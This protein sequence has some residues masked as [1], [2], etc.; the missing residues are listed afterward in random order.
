MRLAILM[1]KVACSA[2]DAPVAASAD[3]EI[4]VVFYAGQASFNVRSLHE[5]QVRTGSAGNQLLVTF[6][7]RY[8]RPHNHSRSLM[9]V[10]QTALTDS[11][12]SSTG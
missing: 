8:R 4:D 7:S 5:A 9:A 1:T 12:D 6:I 3:V 11:L 2:S 10:S